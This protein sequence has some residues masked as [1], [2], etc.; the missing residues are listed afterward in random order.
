[1]SS[2]RT[3][4]RRSPAGEPLVPEQ[5]SSWSRGANRRARKWNGLAAIVLALAGLGAFAVSAG[6]EELSAVRFPGSPLTVFVGPLGQCESNYPNIGNNFYPEGSELGDCGLFLAFPAE[7]GGASKAHAGQP[8]D[9]QGKT[10][11]FSGTAGPGLSTQ[12][13]PVSQ[14]PV[15]GAGTEASPFTQTTVFSV[16]DEEEPQKVY[17]LITETTTY[18]NGAP[19][20]TSTYVVKN[21]TEK[22]GA[23]KLY[24]R[25]I[26][27]GDLYVNGDDFGTGVF[28]AGPPR[29]VGGESAAS[30]VLGGFQEAPA[31]AL[32]WTS[33]QEG[34]WNETP[35]GRCEG[36]APTDQGIWH[37]VRSTVEEA[38]AFNETVDPTLI[39]NAAGVE[40][41]QLR[42]SGLEP[43]HEQ[44]FTIV[45]R[46]QAPNGLQVSP[47]SQ[48]LKQGQTE[49]ITLTALDTAN[50]PYAGKSVPYTVSGANPQSGSVTLNAAGQA[51]ISYVGHNP[52]IDTIQMYVDLGGSGTQVPSDPS[53]TATVTF[54]PLPPAPTPNSSYTV[55]SVKANSNGTITI[56]FVP[57]QAGTATLEVTVPTGTIARRE[58]I[59]A[60]KA[61]RCKKGQLKIKGKCL[62]AT[63]VSGK[64]SA[65]GVAG[66]PLTLSVKPSG[67]INSALKK[68]KTVHLTAT[69]TYTSSLG[70]APTVQTFQVT[71][72]GK[73]AHHHKRR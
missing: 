59:E 29:F 40:W 71:V 11:G 1:M 25:A 5:P 17:A 49:T 6:A 24:F 70:G 68:G 48:T 26:Y 45:N 44:A 10:F 56:V 63:T 65:T 32:P 14:T 72:K 61:K 12:Y 30:G 50:Q 7:G 55:Q 64:V 41:D 39:D 34:C 51:Q 54:T 69:L 73:R 35:E 20:F 27:A 4:G 38:H 13:T 58:A 47:P 33:F 37:D 19:Q 46:T 67:K 8:K 3:D 52:G 9:L 31:P 2:M 66:V 62:P 28:L 42:E 16:N 18:V 22:A 60:R 57:T 43:G 15:T 36:A 53:G 23:T 21:V